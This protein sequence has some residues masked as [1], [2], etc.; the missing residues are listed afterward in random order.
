MKTENLLLIGA[1]AFCLSVVVIAQTSPSEQRLNPQNPSDA[2][3]RLEGAH[4]PI[5][6]H[7]IRRQMPAA[8]QKLPLRHCRLIPHPTRQYHESNLSLTNLSLE[9]WSATRSRMHHYP[10][11]RS[12]SEGHTSMRRVFCRPWNRLVRS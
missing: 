2:D 12:S 5:F 8:L 9:K 6:C 4:A 3:D 1:M 7:R 11:M 10:A